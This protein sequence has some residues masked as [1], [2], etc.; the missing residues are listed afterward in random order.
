M[1]HT[2]KFSVLRKIASGR[3]SKVL[4]LFMVTEILVQAINPL[5][6]MALTTGPTQPEVEG[7]QPAG[8]TDMVDPFTG[9]FSY[10]IPLMDLGGYPLNLSYQ[11][12][13]GMDDEASW[14]GLG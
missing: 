12:G 6:V 14:T 10:N 13:A 8:V 11:S 1:M 2:S 5:A 9:D 7:F 3:W 4:A